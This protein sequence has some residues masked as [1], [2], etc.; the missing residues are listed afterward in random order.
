MLDDVEFAALAQLFLEKHLEERARANSDFDEF[1][2]IFVPN[3]TQEFLLVIE[4]A[5][6]PIEKIFLRS[7]LLSSLKGGILELLPHP[8]FRDAEADLAEFGEYLEKLRKFLQGAIDETGSV[9]AAIDY[10]NREHDKGAMSDAD[11]GR[12]NGDF[13][14]YEVLALQNS[15]HF[16]LQPSFRNFT[17]DCKSFRPDLLF[18]I[19]AKPDLRIVVEC[20]GFAFHSN[21]KSFVSDRKRDRIFAQRGYRVLRF[22]GTEIFQDPPAAATELFCCLEEI[23]AREFPRPKFE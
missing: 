22:S 8:I 13:I 14:K 21:K 17:E 6:S 18:W 23:R 5:E 9:S 16:T 12:L 4:G 1:C 15:F 10:W 3:L 11:F 7:L 20:D 2:R 19:P